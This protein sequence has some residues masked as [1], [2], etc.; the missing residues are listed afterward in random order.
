MRKRGWF[1]IAV[2]LVGHGLCIF[3]IIHLCAFLRQSPA[4]PKIVDT[5][6]EAATDFGSITVSFVEDSPPTEPSAKKKDAEP[7]RKKDNTPL[8]VTDR[9]HPVS[10][11]YH[12]Q[13]NSA[14][15][16]VAPAAYQN[17]GGIALHGKITQ[18]GA[19]IVYVLDQ[20]GSMG[21]ERKL[22]RA[23]ALIKAS[24]RKLGP[25]VRFQ[26]VVYDSRATV[27]RLNRSTDLAFATESNLAEAEALM[28]GLVGEGSS[29]HVEGLLAGLAL[30]PDVLILLTDADELSPA[31]VTRVKQTNFKGTAIHAVLLGTK[32]TGESPLQTLTGPERLHFIR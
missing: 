30:R 27:L 14:S 17:N 25:D 28:D 2:S 31:E 5:R 20:S 9:G 10:N 26:I 12:S 1:A 11:A 4:H 22:L 13:A 8:I 15:P 16:N 7:P 24:L 18:A 6:I 23:I 32:K 29:R 21:R 19:S 3:A